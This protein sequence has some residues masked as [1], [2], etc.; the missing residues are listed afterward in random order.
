MIEQMV[1][2]VF[3]SERLVFDGFPWC[4]NTTIEGF[5]PPPCCHSSSTTAF[6]TSH[7]NYLFTELSHA[8]AYEITEVRNP[9]FI[10]S[11]H[12]S[13]HLL[14]I[15]LCDRN[16]KYNNEQGKPGFFYLSKYSVV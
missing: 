2:I 12:I 4:G 6:I 13:E 15:T 8:L 16:R 3:K 11:S 5:P 14:H 9:I 1:P 10:P 7:F